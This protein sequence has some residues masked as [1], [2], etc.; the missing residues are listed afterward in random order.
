MDVVF[1]QGFSD[2]LLLRREAVGGH[3]LDGGPG[4]NPYG[5]VHPLIQQQP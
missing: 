2:G 4:Q 1:G 3:Q 5:P